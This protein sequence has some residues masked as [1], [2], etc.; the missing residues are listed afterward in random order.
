VKCPVCSEATPIKGPPTGKQYVRCACNCLLICKSSTVRVGCPRP[1]CQRVM[2]LSPPSGD[3]NGTP[4]LENVSTGGT[5]PS[6]GAMRV[7]CGNCHR[8][9]SIPSPAFPGADG[10]PPNLHNRVI[11]CLSAGSASNSSLLIAARCPQCRKVTSVGQGYA[12]VRWTSY[13]IVTLLLLFIAICV[14]WGTVAAAF[15]QKGLYFLWS[16]LYLLVLIFGIRCIMFF[17]MPI[18]ALELSV[19]PRV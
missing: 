18:S 7:I 19:P 6:R 5:F 3:N 9:F 12:R 11:S 14:T 8:P 4:N 16:V 10:A 2:T 13:L 15:N 1:H 17:R